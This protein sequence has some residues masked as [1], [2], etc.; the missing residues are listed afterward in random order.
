EPG[1]RHRAKTSVRS[2][3]Q[4]DRSAA[5]N[6]A[7]EGIARRVRVGREPASRLRREIE[8]LALKRAPAGIAE[9]VIARKDDA[10]A[11]CEAG[12]QLRR[13]VPDGKTAGLACRPRPRFRQRS[14]KP[15]FMLR[16]RIEVEYGTGVERGIE[17]LV[18]GPRPGPNRDLDS[19][20]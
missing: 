7:L 4:R 2:E 13:Q 14:A 6:L 17:V 20:A 1:D 15:T 12:T 9:H 10:R 5:V 3:T 18:P 8:L 11:R 19:G 16:E